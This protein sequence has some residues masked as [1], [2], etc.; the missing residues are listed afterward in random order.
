MPAAGLKQLTQVPLS[1]SLP[2][3]IR[4]IY[5]PPSVKVLT[6]FAR[7]RLPLRYSRHL[8]ISSTDM[9]YVKP[10]GISNLF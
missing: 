6:V 9:C 3:P 10:R 2:P 7:Q 4:G 8:R 5:L 1:L